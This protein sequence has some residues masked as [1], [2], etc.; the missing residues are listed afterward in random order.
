MFDGNEKE[1]YF[2][3]MSVVLNFSVLFVA[4]GV[5][6]TG[7]VDIVKDPIFFFGQ[8]NV[9]GA[10]IGALSG[11]FNIAKHRPTAILGV[12]W[13]LNGTVATFDFGTVF[14]AGNIAPATGQLVFG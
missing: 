13:S 4:D 6:S 11:E 9:G 14:T 3:A 5:S 7:S 2:M 10:V 1:K 8:E 12:G